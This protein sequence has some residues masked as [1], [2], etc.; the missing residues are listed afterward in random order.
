MR[1]YQRSARR[2]VAAVDLILAGLAVSALADPGDRQPK[3]PAPP[4]T[5]ATALVARATMRPPSGVR[6]PGVPRRP[7]APHVLDPD[8]LEPDRHVARR[9]PRLG[10]QP[11][12]RHRHGHPHRRP[13]RSLRTI[14]V[15]DEPQSVALDPSQP[16]RVRRQRGGQLGQRHPD[17]EPE[18]DER[19]P[20]PARPA[21]FTTGA[22]PWN[23][24]VSPDG[25]RVFV[26][27]S[28]QDTITVIDAERP[29]DHRQRRPAPQPLQRPD[30]N[31]H[32]QPRG[33]AVDRRQQ[34]PVRHALPRRSPGRAASRATTTAK[35]GVVCRFDID[36]DSADID[37][38]QPATRITLRRRS[39][40][41][42]STATATARPTRPRAFPNQM[43]SIVIRGDQAYLPNIAASPDGPLRFNVDT[44]AFVN[45]ID[46]VNG[47]SQTRRAARRKFLN[48]HLGARDPEPGKKKLFFANP[49]RSPSPTRAAPASA[50][51]VSAGS[52]LLVKLNVEADGQAQLHRRRATRRA[53][54]T[55]TTPPTRRPTA[56]T[57]ARTRRASSSTRPA[58][59][60]TCMNFVSRNVSVV[61]L[62]TDTRDRGRSRPRRC[63][64]PA[65]QE[66][67]DPRRRGDLLLL[68][69]QLQPAA[70]HDRLDRRAALAATAGR[71]ARAAT[72]RA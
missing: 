28:G 63:R 33:L 2:L 4:T 64:R 52:D 67:V 68:A 25:R 36:T 31:R 46:G 8:Q 34:P 35:Q 14:R 45:V 40:A 37:D 69:R 16:L 1:A 22:E 72:S 58:R 18:P 29:R 3:S 10:R 51:V 71:T 19:V 30:R 60:P 38:Y 57:P 17:H 27:N 12:R 41:S 54:S 11:R 13:T 59:A 21:R 53:T 7:G 6:R 50:Y 65:S 43:Q 47:T 32:F 49:G 70:G 62:T 5:A 24:V 42:T 61:D 56:P 66:E 48:L 23:V 39:P 15:G 26:A 44:Q 55:S 9:P 20:A